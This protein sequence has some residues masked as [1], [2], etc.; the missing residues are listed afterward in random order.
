LVER[1]T[2]GEII[3]QKG[4]G[5]VFPIVLLGVENASF[6]SGDAV[7]NVLDASARLGVGALVSST[8]LQPSSLSSNDT[9]LAEA[10]AAVIGEAVEEKIKGDVLLLALCV[11]LRYVGVGTAGVEKGGVKRVLDVAA[12]G[13]G[14]LDSSTFLPPSVRSPFE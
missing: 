11:L 9:V 14:A 1:G 12:T 6:E 5:A 10:G 8:F 4:K 2:I 7:E 3:E 13:I